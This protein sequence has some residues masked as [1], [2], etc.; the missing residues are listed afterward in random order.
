MALRTSRAHV[1]EYF[2][3]VE[4]EM[5]TLHSPTESFMYLSHYSPLR[6]YSILLC[7]ALMRVRLP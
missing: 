2:D 5:R 7:E 6:T 1:E 4:H 3:A